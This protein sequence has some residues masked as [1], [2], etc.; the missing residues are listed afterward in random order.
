MS[1]YF[2]PED[3]ITRDGVVSNITRNGAGFISTK[4]GDDIFVPVRIVDSS[5]IEM[6]DSVTVYIVK[7]F[8]DATIPNIRESAPYRALRVVINKR[9][10]MDTLPV[11]APVDPLPAPVR[12]IEEYT[13]VPV[14]QSQDKEKMSGA[15][16]RH[17][18]EKMITSGFVGTSQMIHRELVRQFP[19]VDLMNDDAGLRVKMD[20]SSLL[21]RMH[22]DGVIAYARICTSG[23]QKNSSYSV[24]GPTAKGL[25]SAI[26]GA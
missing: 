2:S 12:A 23:D 10:G 24:Y 5:G 3:V 25:F 15:M 22:D 26:I 1:N 6:G 21:H 18:V 13:D 14:Q 11:T 7:N 4:E 20:I 19:D 17:S 16:L 8:G 9:I